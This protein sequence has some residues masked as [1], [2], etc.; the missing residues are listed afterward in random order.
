V[1]RAGI[2]MGDVIASDVTPLAW[3]LPGGV[4]PPPPADA[5]I[6]PTTTS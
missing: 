3:P 1:E 4:L 5:P 6:A 2:A